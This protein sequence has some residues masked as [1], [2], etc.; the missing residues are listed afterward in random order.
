MAT[1]GWVQGG[2]WGPGGYRVGYTQG[3]TTHPPRE[4]PNEEC[5][6]QPACWRG[7]GVL[8]GGNACL[9]FGGG[10]GPGTTTPCGRARSRWSLYQDPQNAASGQ[11]GRDSGHISVKLVKTMECH[12]KSGKRPTIVPIS[13][14]GSRSR[15]LIFSDFHF[16]QPSLARN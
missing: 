7:Q 12:R 1:A 2:V 6:K 15:L 4:E 8:G 14:T 9:V 3:S 10:T 16:R 11:Y 13:K 5:P